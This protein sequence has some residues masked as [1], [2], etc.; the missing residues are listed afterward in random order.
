MLRERVTSSCDLPVDTLPL[1]ERFQY[2]DFS[3]LERSKAQDFWIKEEL[4]KNDEDNPKRW[5]AETENTLKLN[6]LMKKIHPE[7]IESQKALNDRTQNFRKQ[8]LEDRGFADKKILIVSHSAFLE[9]F[10]ATKYWKDD[11]PLDGNY[12]KNAEFAEVTL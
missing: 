2:M 3:F 6:E 12:L 4:E 11:T 9:S 10:T 7:T 5:L 1:K 8:L